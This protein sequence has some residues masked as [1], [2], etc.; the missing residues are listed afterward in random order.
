MAAL[1]KRHGAVDEAHAGQADLDQAVVERDLGA[2]D[3]DLAGADS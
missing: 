3:L 1:P 2:A